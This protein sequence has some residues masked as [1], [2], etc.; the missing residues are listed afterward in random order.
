MVRAALSSVCTMCGSQ[1]MRG[2]QLFRRQDTT[3]F[4][5]PPPHPHPPLIPPH[6]HSPS[7]HLVTVSLGAK[8]QTYLPDNCLYSVTS[9]CLS[10]V[11][12]YES[13]MGDKMCVCV[14]A[15]VCA[16]V[17]VCAPTGFKPGSQID[18]S[19]FSAPFF[20][21]FDVSQY[22]CSQ[23]QCLVPLPLLV[24]LALLS[25]CVPPSCQARLLFRCLDLVETKH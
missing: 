21:I 19:A 25:I 2:S 11:L 9:L 14:C 18:L 6:T 1:L 22:T 4:Y 13:V 23:N 7:N 20:G 12:C 15:C 10:G 5:C 3:H 17:C 16:C 24:P 8:K